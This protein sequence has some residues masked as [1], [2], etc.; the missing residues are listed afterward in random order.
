MNNDIYYMRLALEQAK[1][2][3]KKGEVPIGCVIIHNGKVIA[4]AYNLRETKKDPLAHAE[5]IAIRKASRALH[6]WRLQGCTLYVTLEPCPM[7]AGAVINARIPHVVYGASD[8]KAGCFGSLYDF[9]SGG[10][11]HIPRIT[12]G[13]LCEECA[14]LLKDF[15]KLK[16]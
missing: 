4:K 6:G 3:Y 11:N 12:S 1:T 5:L 16:R 15:F 14:L 10:F 13:I 8:P 7:C 9:T 2:A